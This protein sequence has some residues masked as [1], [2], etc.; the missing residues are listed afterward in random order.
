VKTFPDQQPQVERRL[1]RSCLVKFWWT[2]SFRISCIDETASGRLLTSW[3]RL[4]HPGIHEN[5]NF[6]VSLAWAVGVMS[7]GFWNSNVARAAGRILPSKEKRQHGTTASDRYDYVMDEEGSPSRRSSGRTPRSLRQAIRQKPAALHRGGDQTSGGSKSGSW[8]GC[9]WIM[10]PQTEV[11]LLGVAFTSP[12]SRP[13]V[14]S[15]TRGMT[16]S[17]RNTVIEETGPSRHEQS[18]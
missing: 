7:A 10:K 17:Q 13:T 5:Q 6:S 15:G 18:A 4:H 11:E 16:G 3:R 14:S 12:S 8:Q 2:Y 1:R 9:Y